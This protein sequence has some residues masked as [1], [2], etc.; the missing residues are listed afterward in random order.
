MAVNAHL[1]DHPT[2]HIRQGLETA[3]EGA[4]WRFAP[5]RQSLTLLDIRSDGSGGIR[6]AGN[7][8]SDAMK[9]IAARIARGVPG[10]RSVDD[11]L[12]SDSTLESTLAVAVAE[13]PDARLYTDT[14]TISS[15]LG[16]VYLGGMIAREDLAEAERL[17][18]RVVELA[19][20]TPGVVAVVDNIRAVQGTGV[21]YVVEA[22]EA[23]TDEPVATGARAMG[24]LIPEERREKIRAMIKARAASAG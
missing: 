18:A 2:E 23:A 10:V 1:I 21:V 4:L 14:L 17:R 3:V 11:Q 20:G 15:I 19:E 12:H 22:A 24:S 6:L 13:D 7:I 8:R 9:A 16:T 5:I